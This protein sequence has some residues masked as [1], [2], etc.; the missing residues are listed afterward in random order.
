ME[1]PDHDEVK[2]KVRFF[3]GLS[4]LADVMELVY[5]LCSD[6]RAERHVSSILTVSTNDQGSMDRREVS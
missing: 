6:H 4:N 1:N 2:T 3:Q 5:I